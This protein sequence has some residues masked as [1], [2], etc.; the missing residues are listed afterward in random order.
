MYTLHVESVHIWQRPVFIAILCDFV[1]LPKDKYGG[2]F[3][4]ARNIFPFLHV[5]T[6]ISSRDNQVRMRYLYTHTCTN[7]H[8]LFVVMYM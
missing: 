1:S 5:I 7:V 2:D 3:T 8:F 6:I 4:Y